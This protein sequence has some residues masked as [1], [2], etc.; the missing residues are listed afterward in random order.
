M[1]KTKII[2]PL[3]FILLLLIIMII[4]PINIK[5]NTKS[6]KIEEKKSEKKEEIKESKLS[7]VMV[8]DA[9]LHGSVYKDA[10]IN[11]TYDFTKQLELIKPIIKNYDLAFYN[12]ETI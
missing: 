4:L 2:K 1:K 10:Y 5:E 6:E 12:Q 3:T 9:L 8:G 7:L 11:G